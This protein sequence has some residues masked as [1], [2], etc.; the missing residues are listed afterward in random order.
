MFFVSALVIVLSFLV[1][2]K[3]LHDRRLRRIPIRIHVN[4]TRGKSTVTRLIASRL[5]AAGVRTVAKTTGDRPIF[6]GPD[7]REEAIVRRAP[8]R[9]QEQ[10]RLVK[11]AAALGA[12]AIVVECM[13]LDPALQHASESRMI[14]STLGV[15]TNVR[16]DHFEIMGADLD[17]IAA[18]LS[19]TIPEQGILVTADHRYLDYFRERAR[20]KK[21]QV[22]L[23]VNGEDNTD[24]FPEK[25]AIVKS[26]CE[27]VSLPAE[28]R[29]IPQPER[30]VAWRIEYRGKDVYFVDAFS[31]NDVESMHDIEEALLQ[32]DSYPRPL[33]AL[34]NNRSDRPLR[35]RSFT[36]YLS[37][38]RAY[39]FIG[40]VGSNAWLAERMLRKGGRTGG[41]FALS[42]RSADGVLE[43]IGRRAGASW[44]TVVGMGNYKSIG[45][46]MRRL[47]E[48]K[49]EPCS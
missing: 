29:E 36:S 5:R 34:L 27:S 28:R 48:T 35:M 15:I 30:P 46:A 11:R 26:V 24:L 42:A 25:F 6:I 38:N 4:G 10:V 12:Q 47:L 8:S 1:I 23:A 44:Y 20:K 43:E 33:I 16:S 39:S 9:I 14:R 45:G 3:V 19:R 17:G 41:V 21:T 7:G 32:N 2:E 31:A 49:G 37:G 22:L 40:L 18:S 13:A